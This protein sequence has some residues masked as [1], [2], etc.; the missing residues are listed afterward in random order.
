V[1]TT[2]VASTAQGAPTL[3]S[4]VAPTRSSADHEVN[5]M[6]EASERGDRHGQ[7]EE[8]ALAAAP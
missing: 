1:P 2:P 6:I 4:P 3:S 5:V 7:H 8:P